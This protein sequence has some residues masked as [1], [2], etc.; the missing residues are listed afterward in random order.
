MP[1][2]FSIALRQ[3]LAPPTFNA[4]GLATWLRDWIELTWRP[5][6]IIVERYMSPAWQSS[7]A[8]VIASQQAHGAARGVAACY[9]IRYA[10]PAAS[11]VR[12][13]F[14]GRGAPPKDAKDDRR[15][16][17]NP[18][19]NMVIDSAIRRGFLAA[20][21]RDDDKADASA[22]FFYA[23]VTYADKMPWRPGAGVLD[24]EPDLLRRTDSL[25]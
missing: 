1:R 6:L 2:P 25:V 21:D 24:P 10:D 20:D 13:L 7:Q 16:G 23:S 8:E 3:E 12:K 17:K 19:K 18:T 14:C 9:D 4:A 22:L 11:T 15:G 5:D